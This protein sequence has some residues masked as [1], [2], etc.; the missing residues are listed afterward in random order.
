MTEIQLENENVKIQ[1]LTN[2]YDEIMKKN[3]EM[4]YLRDSTNEHALK[5]I[6]NRV[7]VTTNK[8]D[9][10][11]YK[12]EKDKLRD[13][14]KQHYIVCYEYA[15]AISGRKRVRIARN[16]WISIRTLDRMI[17]ARH[18][19]SAMLQKYGD[20][21]LQRPVKFLQIKCPNSIELWNLVREL[22]PHK[23]YG[24]IFTN[25]S[26]AEIELLSRDQLLE[27]YHQDLKFENPMLQKLKLKGKQDLLEKCF[28][29]DEEC[30][31]L[32]THI[33]NSTIDH[34]KY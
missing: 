33:I 27:K 13:A 24:F 4:K 14:N 16:Q 21:L 17:K 25:K 3:N 22:Y 18:A 15:C 10:Q 12:K 6:T 32:F 7:N 19:S 23:F 29:S 31:D 5:D 11:A 1:Q 34:I 20:W 30:K 28:T 2:E 8:K 26:C 9:T